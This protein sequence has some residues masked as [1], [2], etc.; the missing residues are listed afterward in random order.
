MCINYL[1]QVPLYGSKKGQDIEAIC[2]FFDI[3]PP[4]KLIE[5]VADP[6]DFTHE[7]RIM[8]NHFSGSTDHRRVSSPRPWGCFLFID[9]EGYEVGVEIDGIAARIARIPGMDRGPIY[10]DS[11]RPETISYVA[12][13]GI[14]IHPAPKW[15]GSVEDGI[16]F[17][18][19]FEEI[20]IH[21]RCVHMHEEA[22]LY[23]YKADKLTGEV[24]PEVE[25]RN[26]HL[27]D[28]VR[29]ALSPYIQK[30][31]TPTAFPSG[32]MGR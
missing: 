21:E 29:Y 10:A 7:S 22:R 31:I 28:A 30:K 32:L 9:H 5:I 17:L 8:L 16:E 19:S 14:N 25:D 18:R 1:S 13:R 24:L 11:A 12:R 15:K 20:V 27:W 6:C 2:G 26:N 23:S 3:A 4:R